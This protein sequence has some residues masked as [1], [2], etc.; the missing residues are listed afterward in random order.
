MPILKYG[1]SKPVRVC[2]I[3]ADVLIVGPAIG[4]N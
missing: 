4:A 1:L 2:D 3:C